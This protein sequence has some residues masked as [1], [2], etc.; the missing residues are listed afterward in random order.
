[1]EKRRDVSGRSLSP[2]PQPGARSRRS[3]SRSRSPEPPPAAAVPG[4]PAPAEAQCGVEVRA[5]MRLEVRWTIADETIW[6]PCTI[7]GV[8]GDG[9][10]LRELGNEWEVTY[11]AMPEYEYEEE[12]RRVIFVGRELLVDLE[13]R[14]E[15]EDGEAEGGLMQ[16]RPEGDSSEPDELLQAGTR[17]KARWQGGPTFHTGR[18]AALNYDGTYAI[19]YADGDVEPEVPR[20]L[21]EVVEIDDASSEGGDY[22]AQEAGEVAGTDAMFDLVI[23][24]LVRGP[25][26]SQL[27]SDQ[28]LEASTKIAGL[29]VLFEAEL[30]KIKTERGAGALVT[31]NDVLEILPRILGMS[32]AGDSQ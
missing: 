2:Q 16:W 30:E 26:F 10:D 5:G 3:R 8:R 20:N 23:G 29:K 19:D 18:V 21:I 27:P 12:H 4:A 22:D 14:R 11:D 24:R 15:A 17:V 25:V 32:Q 6:W 1:M 28:Q 31:Q 7:E 13:T 9:G